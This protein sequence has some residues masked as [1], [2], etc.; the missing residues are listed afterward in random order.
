MANIVLTD[1]HVLLRN[2]L[3]GLLSSLGHTI[4]YEADNGHELIKKINAKCLPDIVVMDINMPV[5]D[6]C[7][8]TLWLRKHYPAVKV[9]ALSMYNDESAI[10]RM[11]GCGAK[12]YIL[13]DSKPAQMQ[14]AID[15]IMKDGFHYSELLNDKLIYA[16]NKIGDDAVTEMS[17]IIDITDREMEFLRLCCTELTYREIAEKLLVS[18]RTVDSYRDVLFDKLKVKTRVGLVMYAVKNGIIHI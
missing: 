3:A 8:A 16:I 12:G 13:K 9:L 1:D 6:G 14:E 15:A 10:I 7:E 5:M 18:P 17:K 2:G 4:L 11:L